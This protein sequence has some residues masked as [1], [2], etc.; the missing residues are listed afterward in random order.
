MYANCSIHAGRVRAGLH[1][2]LVAETQEGATPVGPERCTLRIGIEIE[3][4][5]QLQSLSSAPL[6]WPHEWKIV[7]AT[8]D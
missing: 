1:G 2:H 8:S 4:A 5:H 3:T 6:N 7:L